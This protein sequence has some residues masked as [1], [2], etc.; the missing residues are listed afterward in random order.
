MACPAKGLRLWNSDCTK[1]AARHKGQVVAG[2]VVLVMLQDGEPVPKVIDFGVAKALHHIDG[3]DI[4]E[5][6]HARHDEP[7]AQ[8]EH[9]PVPFAS[10]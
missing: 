1:S 5:W 3:G 4:D 8:Q 9:S 10:P 6:R 2:S 7:N